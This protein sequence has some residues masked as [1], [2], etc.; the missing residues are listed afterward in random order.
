MKN[1]SLPLILA[2]AFFVKPSYQA[3]KALPVSLTGSQRDCFNYVRQTAC[4]ECGG[5]DGVAITYPYSADGATADTPY[6]T[7]QCNFPGACVDSVQRNQCTWRRYH[8]ELC[9]GSSSAPTLISAT[10]S[11][12][13]HCYYSETSPPFGSAS[14]FNTYVFV[15]NWNLDVTQLK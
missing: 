10:N 9:K 7:V 12:P 3:A 15:R 4:T 1:P 2:I 14:A 8:G 11:L 5:V 6:E 13:N